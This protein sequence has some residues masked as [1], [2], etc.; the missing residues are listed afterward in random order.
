MDITQEFAD[1][2]FIIT[3]YQPGC[4]LINNEPHRQSFIISTD[5]LITPWDVTDVTKLKESSVNLIIQKQP[6]IALFGTGG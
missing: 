3:G 2:K 5:T 4:V 1:A 6:E